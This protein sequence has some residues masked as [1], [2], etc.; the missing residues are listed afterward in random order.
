MGALIF[1]RYLFSH[2]PTISGNNLATG[3][4]GVWSSAYCGMCISKQWQKRFSDSA[5]AH[6]RMDEYTYD[7]AVRRDPC[8]ATSSFA[9]YRN[10]AKAADGVIT[11]AIN[12]L[13]SSGLLGATYSWTA[14]GSG[15]SIRKSQK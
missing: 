4:E 11:H 6:V 3:T 12:V 5:A 7:V 10:F 15:I 1:R 8:M 13:E 9:A 2:A 14:L